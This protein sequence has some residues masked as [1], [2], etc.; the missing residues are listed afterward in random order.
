MNI[1]FF[2]IPVESIDVSLKFYH[3]FLGFTLVKRYIAG[4]GVEIAF[5]ADGK[6]SKIELIK[7]A[8][9]KKIGD[10]PVSIGFETDD[11]EN[12]RTDF[13]T[14]GYKG[15]TEI[16]TTPKGVKL[17]YLFDPDGMKLLFVQF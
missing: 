5:I 8:D 14:K 11:I 17:L 1:S 10:C 9:D 7:G 2:T 3:D 4:P 13:I 6:G 15:S 16:V 12:A